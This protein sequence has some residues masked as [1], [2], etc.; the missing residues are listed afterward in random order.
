MSRIAV[1]GAGAWG[2]AL[3]IVLA[4]GGAHEVRLWAYEQEV[5]ES[6]RSRRMNDLFLPGF[7]LPDRI[8]ITNS[9]AAALEGAQIVLTVMPSH[10][11]RRLYGDMRPSLPRGVTIVSAT[12]GI[13]HQT[14]K[15]MTEVAA[16]VSGSDRVAALSGPSFAKEVARGDPT[17]LTVASPNSEVAALVQREFSDPMFRVYTSD[18]V[19]GVELGGA[20][21][22]VIA[23]AAGIAEGLGF[24]HN[25]AA[26]L[27]TRGLA[28]IT[29]LAVAC[30]A[31][32]ETLS[33]L[34]GIGDLVLTCTGGLSRNR[35]VGVELGR[36]RKLHD[37]MAGMHGMVAEGVLTT[38]AA[39]GLAQMYAME[40]PI[41]EQM[42]AI[43]HEEK[44]AKDAI[45]EL[46]SRP[47]KEE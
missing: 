23:I 31:R 11:A 29:R 9:L 22:N 37:I 25:T 7:V 40:M 21:K 18:D 39:L 33:G 10:H 15:R 28:E 8:A 17:A 5:L 36:G 27:I 16:E 2:T 34:S 13:E 24:G 26:A 19:V 41:S 43:L 3:S 46:M 20:L 1:I 38:D 42:H 45:R 44:P 14:Y 4:R 30:G 32:R 12:K 47:G 6:I 35:T